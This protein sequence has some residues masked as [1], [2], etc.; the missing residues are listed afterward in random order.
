MVNPF[1]KFFFKDNSASQLDQPISIPGK[2][3]DVERIKIVEVGSSGVENQSGYLYEEYLS[4]LTGSQRADVYD[5]MRRSDSNVSMVL[6]SMKS[7]IKSGEWNWQQGDKDTVEKYPYAE[8]DMK[9]IEHVFSNMIWPF[10][11]ILEESTTVIEF[12]LAAFEKTHKIVLDDPIFGSYIGLKNIGWRSPKTIERFN[13]DRDER[14][15]SITQMSYGDASRYVDIPAQFLTLLTI[16]QEGANYEGISLLRPCYGNWFR[17]NEYLKFQASGI[18]K[19]AIPTPIAKV[20]AGFEGSP[21]QD[22]LER[23]LQGYT[24]NGKKYIIHPEGWDINLHPNTGFDPAKIDA[25]I[26]NEDKRMT[27]AVLA[28]FLEL[29]MSGGGGSHALSADLSDF[30]MNSLQYIARIIATAWSNVAKE[31]IIINF[32]PREVYPFLTCTGINDQA[33]T[34]LATIIQLLV[35]AGVIVADDVLEADVRE[36][37]RLPAKSDIGQ[38]QKSSNP[39]AQ[40]NEHSL[41]ARIQAKKNQAKLFQQRVK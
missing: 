33:G 41:S 30:F 14:L 29:G 8:Q 24:A 21:E 12:G 7:P 34:E 11:K 15:L 1:K 25:A 4:T 31:L 3:L 6:S 10:S 17:K 32:G 18:E 5:K 13:I 27:K 40:F 35:N 2:D 28:N 9:F 26:D 39:F 19:S 23:F 38:R 22:T 20:P 37:Y 16:N 36:K